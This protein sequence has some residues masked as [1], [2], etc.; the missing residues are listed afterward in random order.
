[1]RSATFDAV[2]IM[3]QVMSKFERPLVAEVFRIPFSKARG[4]QEGKKG[5]PGSAN[6]GARGGQQ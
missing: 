1:M 6:G 5:G 2:L 4:E 3:L